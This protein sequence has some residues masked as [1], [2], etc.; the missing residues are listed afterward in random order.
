MYHLVS[1]Q[2]NVHPR[3]TLWF[4]FPYPYGEIVKGFWI[5]LCNLQPFNAQPE[6]HI[7]DKLRVISYNRAYIE[8][9]RERTAIAS[10]PFQQITYG[11]N[12]H[13]RPDHFYPWVSMFSCV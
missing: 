3:P 13:L 12:A 11:I 1:S 9:S 8:Y 6:A 5:T 7:N 2:V 4:L 10:F